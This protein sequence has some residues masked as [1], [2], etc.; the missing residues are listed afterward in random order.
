MHEAVFFTNNLPYA[1]AI[2]NGH[3]FR[4]PGVMVAKNVLRFKR[5]LSREALKQRRKKK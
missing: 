5:L 2:E 1:E 4:H 3:G